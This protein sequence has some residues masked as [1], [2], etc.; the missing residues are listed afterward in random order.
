VP[1]ESHGYAI[2]WDVRTS[3]HGGRGA[4]EHAA[5]DAIAAAAALATD[6]LDVALPMDDFQAPGEFRAQL[7]DVFAERALL[8][9]MDRVGAPAAAD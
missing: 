8:E 6:D 5:E 9:A 7:R 1:P 2:R 3:G 4:V